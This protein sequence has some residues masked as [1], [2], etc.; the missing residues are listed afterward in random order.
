MGVVNTMS[1]A[2]LKQCAG[3]QPGQLEVEANQ[4]AIHFQ[5][6]PGLL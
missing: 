5:P 2:L 6:A 1:L 3:P 4:V